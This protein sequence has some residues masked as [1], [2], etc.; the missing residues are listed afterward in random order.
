MQG[1]VR[2]YDPMGL[3]L[4]RTDGDGHSASVTSRDNL[5]NPAGTTDRKGQAVSLGYDALSR[6]SSA[7]YADSSTTAW[8]TDLGNRLTQIQDSAGG[9]LAYTYDGFDRVL[10]ETTSQGTVT[11]TYDAAGRRTTLS[12]PG[13]S[14]ITYSYDNANRLTGITQGSASLAFGYDAA[15]R[16]TSTTL[17]NGITLGDDLFR[18]IRSD[19]PV[20]VI[21]MRMRGIIRP[22][23]EIP[24]AASSSCWPYRQLSM[25]PR[26]CWAIWPPWVAL[27]T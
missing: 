14:Q 27:A 19:W 21:C 25:A 1:M 8:S 22:H 4:T 20:G 10:T 17:P 3:P 6:L 16:R 7:S 5:G 9:T 15:N 23:S 26:Q 18:K 11:Y 2:T 12:A 24:M 13:Q